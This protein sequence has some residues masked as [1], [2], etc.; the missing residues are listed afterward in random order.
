MAGGAHPARVEEVER[1]DVQGGGNLHP[2]AQGDEPFGEF[3][4]P[5]AVVQAA[6]DVRGGHGHKLLCPED[7]RHPHHDA[8]GQLRRGTALAVQDRAF[9]VG[10]DQGG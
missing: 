5:V 4:A 7:A 9:L 8:H 2:P 6:V 1:A 3:D 10:E